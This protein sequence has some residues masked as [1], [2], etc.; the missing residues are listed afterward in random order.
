M[1]QPPIDGVLLAECSVQEMGRS[2]KGI[3]IA[4]LV[5]MVK[6]AATGF[7]RQLAFK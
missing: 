5:V 3:Y 2:Q 7:L 1:S 4:F 6:L